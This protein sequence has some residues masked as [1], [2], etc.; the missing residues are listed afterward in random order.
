[1]RTLAASWPPSLPD[2]GQGSKRVSI[3][4]H[5]ARTGLWCFS[6]QSPR[7][8]RPTTKLRP[9]VI[10]RPF[11]GAV[12]RPNK[13]RLTDIVRSAAGRHVGAA[14][15]NSARNRISRAAAQLRPSASTRVGVIPAAGVPIDAAAR[16]GSRARPIL[17]LQGPVFGSPG[18]RPDRAA[19]CGQLSSRR[20]GSRRLDRRRAA[21]RG[22]LTGVDDEP[23]SFSRVAVSA[24]PSTSGSSVTSAGN[25]VSRI[26]G[27]RSIGE[28]TAD[29]AAPALA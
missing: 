14:G 12:G 7:H 15:T 25:S 26:S 8:S 18:L 21:N 10:G 28:R 3:G 9:G 19:L 24:R 1:M 22:V 27:K 13:R 11:R 17:A 2:R 16:C 20:V 5:H 4:R 23:N 6:S 29:S